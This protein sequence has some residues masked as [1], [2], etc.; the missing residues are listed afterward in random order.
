MCFSFIIETLEQLPSP[1]TLSSA[2]AALRIMLHKSQLFL[3]R[4]T[5]PFESE[6]ALQIYEQSMYPLM[7]LLTGVVYTDRYSFIPQDAFQRLTSVSSL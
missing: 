6:I 2:D 3:A 5:K 4:M 1:E 7:L